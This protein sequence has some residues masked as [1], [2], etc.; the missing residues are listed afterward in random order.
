MAKRNL[1][2]VF[3]LALVLSSCS[4][5]GKQSLDQLSIEDRL[6]D[7]FTRYADS[8][9]FSG[10]ALVAR[11]D[12]ILLRRGYGFANREEQIP[13]APDTQFHIQS[14]AKLY[15]YASVLMEVKA[16][17]VLP[18]DPIQ[19][20]IPGFP[21]GDKITVDHLLRHRSGIFHYPHEIPGHVYGS[22]SAPIEIDVLIDEFEGFPL[23][24]EPGTQYNYSNA[25]YSMLAK[26]VEEVSNAPFA[27]YLQAKI[28]TPI[29]MVQTTADWDSASQDLAIGYEKLD[30]E[31]IR[32]P[33]DHPSHF[34]GA[35]T[36]YST[37][38]DMYQWY[39]AVYI[40]GSMREFS[41]GGGDGRGMGYRA[42]FWPIP[43][44]DLVII[45]LSN[46]MDAPVDELVG[47]VAAILLE[48]TTFID[49]DLDDL[50]ALRG[51]YIAD[52]GF[53]DFSFSIYGSPE[54]LFVSVTDFRG[55][56]LIY[57]L[58]PIAP[59]QFAFLKEGRLTG[60]TLAFKTE[61]DA[62]VREVLVDLNVL[63][64]EATRSD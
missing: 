60:Q 4:P 52:S 11:G 14:I 48:E 24:F 10:S 33:A 38:D 58:R 40:D 21:D 64:L 8:G 25:G 23:K 43:S 32:S 61:D 5:I 46:Y 56:P 7:L 20:Y 54:K 1:L 47:E 17:R 59:N 6:D 28:F 15:T 36:T 34:V 13:N 62:N 12:Q 49:H 37:V 27:E 55:R 42:I 19:R 53:G 18:D 45:I 41:S 16:G 29:G 31:I 2:Y 30:G 3:C 51:Q 50:E 35:G 39:Q 44:F 9:E 22:L 26:I 63:Q 57:E